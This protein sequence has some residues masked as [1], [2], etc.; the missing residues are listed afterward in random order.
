[1][2]TCLK[3]PQ[4]LQGEGEAWQGDRDLPNT[5]AWPGMTESTGFQRAVSLAVG[6]LPVS[7]VHGILQARILEEVAIPFSRGSSWSRDWTALQVDSSLSEPPGKPL[8]HTTSGE[9]P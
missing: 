8:L 2:W 5:P 9:K 1:M 4:A 3:N 7:S 6:V